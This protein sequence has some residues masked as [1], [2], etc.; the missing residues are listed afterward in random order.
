M[1]H[2]QAASLST[3]RWLDERLVRPGWTRRGSPGAEQPGSRSGLPARP[4]RA[5]EEGGAAEACPCPRCKRLG[6]VRAQRARAKRRR[7]GSRTRG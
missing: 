1:S 6:A 5:A 4:T 2:L 7:A 3:L